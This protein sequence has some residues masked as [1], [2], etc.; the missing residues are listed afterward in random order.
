MHRLQACN[1]LQLPGRSHES[2]IIRGYRAASAVEAQHTHMLCGSQ[3]ADCNP[4]W[5]EKEM[6][7]FRA[8][9]CSCRREGS[10]HCRQSLLWNHKR[11]KSH[12]NVHEGMRSAPQLAGPYTDFPATYRSAARPQALHA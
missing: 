6:E 12:S 3:A 8:Y 11:P 1:C 7:L 10:W 5:G 9:D 2:V 4:N